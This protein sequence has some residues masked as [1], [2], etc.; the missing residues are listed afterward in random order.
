MEHDKR[1]ERIQQVANSLKRLHVVS[2][3]DEAIERAKEIVG[4]SDDKEKSIKELME[5]EVKKKVKDVEREQAGAEKFVEESGKSLSGKANDYLED[6]DESIESAD[7]TIAQTEAVHG[8]L[9]E[10]VNI[11]E[12][13]TGD[14]EESK[15]ELDVIRH[16]VEDT[17]EIA[18]QADKVK[19][20]SKK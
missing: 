5:A 14:V 19:K 9:A 11:H 2:T 3:M 12:L 10:D 4:D 18:R 13:E 6:V 7:E 8:E 20:K 17:E 15:R 16:A 1:S